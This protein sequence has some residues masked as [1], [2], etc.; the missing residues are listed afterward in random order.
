MTYLFKLCDICIIGLEIKMANTK[1]DDRF[2]TSTRGRIVLL[3][4][5]T[6]QTVNE[7][8]AKLD[9][10]DNAVRAHLVVL[11][12]DGLVVQGGSIKG[13]RKPHYIYQLTDEARHLFPKSYDSLFNRILAQFKLSV[14]AAKIKDVIRAAGRKMGADAV[15]EHSAEMN[16]RIG[17]A[18]AAL[19]DFGGTAT[20]SKTDGVVVISS[21]SCPFA[22]VVKEHPDVCGLTEAMLEE[23]T[24]VPVKETCDR[25]TMPKCRFELPETGG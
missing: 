15:K 19:E 11:E 14:P 24:G 8:A 9:V 4:R 7:L 5:E 25:R 22:D 23:I 1:I 2:F 6:P 20:V 13:F 21:N 12:R 18:I 3:L 10:T 17:S 16:D